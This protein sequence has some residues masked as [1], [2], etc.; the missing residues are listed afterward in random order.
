MI[1]III[2]LLKKRLCGKKGTKMYELSKQSSVENFL[3]QLHFVRL[4]LMRM[5]VYRNSMLYNLLQSCDQLK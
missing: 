4:G 1:N 2:I 5:L 3:Q